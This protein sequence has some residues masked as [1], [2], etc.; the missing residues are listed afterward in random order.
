MP[1]PLA[2]VQTEICVDQAGPGPQILKWNI[3]ITV[4]RNSDRYPAH[5]QVCKQRFVPIWPD[6]SHSFYNR[7]IH[8]I[9]YYERQVKKLVGNYL[10]FEVCK[11]S[12][13]KLECGINGKVLQDCTC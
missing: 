9:I 3:K 13:K 8:Y 4:T 6:W 7:K 11:R 1:R 2:G 10:D 12:Q 5:Q